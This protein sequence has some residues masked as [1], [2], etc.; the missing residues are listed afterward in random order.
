MNGINV[1]FLP[2]KTHG[3]VTYNDDD[4][5][6]IFINCNDSVERQRQTFVHE[7]KHIEGDDFDLKDVQFSEW[8]AN[9]K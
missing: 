1:F 3:A 5:Y 4:S 9:L 2:L 6:T 8:R 7:M